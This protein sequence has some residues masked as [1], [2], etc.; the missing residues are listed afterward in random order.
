MFVVAPDGKADAAGTVAAPTTL[1]AAVTR[2]VT[3][4]AI[5]LRGGTYRT[6]SLEIQPRH[7]LAALPGRAAGAQGTQL[8]TT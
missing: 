4:D 2:V 7:H 5:V 6:G 8:A 1:E 3:G